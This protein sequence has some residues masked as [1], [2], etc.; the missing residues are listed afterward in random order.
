MKKEET[1][2][3]NSRMSEQGR[4]RMLDIYHMA[5]FLNIF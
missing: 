1:L 3:E 2:Y 5:T 4:R